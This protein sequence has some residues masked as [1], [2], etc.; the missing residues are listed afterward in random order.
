M[1]KGSGA[2]RDALVGAMALAGGLRLAVRERSLWRPWLLCTLACLAIWMAVV[3]SAAYFGASWVDHW[4]PVPVA[5]G[6]AWPRVLLKFAYWLLLMAVALLVASTVAMWLCAPLLSWIAAATEEKLTGKRPPSRP[7][8][9]EIGEFLRSAGRGLV[10]F[11]LQ[12]TGSVAIAGTLGLLGLFF[13]PAW[14]CG[15]ILAWAWNAAMVAIFAMSFSF[16]HHGVP[17]KTQLITARTRWAALVGFGAAG[18]WLAA[19]PVLLP[20]VVVG[21]TALAIRL[22]HE[23]QD[24]AT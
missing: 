13:P 2:G 24:R 8:A 16:D 4:V 18:Q 19:V 12:L 5:T 20:P 23:D 10:W 17:L 7:V 9:A 22:R 3:G 21:A 6:A 11:A 1:N 15:A 14:L